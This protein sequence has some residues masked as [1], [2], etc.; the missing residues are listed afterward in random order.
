MGFSYSRLSFL[1]TYLFSKC[2]LN[3]FHVLATVQGVKNVTCNNEQDT[4]SLSFHWGSPLA[5]NNI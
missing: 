1:F 2:L 3:A 5:W 4:Y